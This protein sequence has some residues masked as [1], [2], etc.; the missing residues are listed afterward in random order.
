[1]HCTYARTARTIRPVRTRH[2]PAADFTRPGWLPVDWT[3]QVKGGCVTAKS[4][5]F[6]FDGR[7][8]RQVVEIRPF[9]KGWEVIDG[10]IDVETGCP[11]DW[12]GREVFKTFN[13][14]RA[15]AATLIC[16]EYDEDD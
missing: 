8:I 12:P 7:E 14:A 6:L 3:W 4:A 1:M 13:G 16:N 2:I 5:P 10:V 15:W 11:E 9:A